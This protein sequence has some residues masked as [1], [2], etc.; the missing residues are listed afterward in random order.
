MNDQ[1]VLQDFRETKALLD[2]HFLLRSGLHSERYFQCALV[3]QYPRRAAKLCSELA[4]KAAGIGAQTVISPALGGLFVGQGVGHALDL[5]HIFLEKD[6]VG[7]LVL[8]RGFTIT[9]GE[10]FLVAED[11]VTKGGRV[12][13][14]I[15]VVRKMGGV[16]VGACV[17]VDRSDGTTNFDVP[18]WSLLKMQFPT[19]APADCP[20]CRDKIPVEKPGSK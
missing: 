9:P 7:G 19:F 4:K 8:R 14:T 15:D 3:L 6:D 5:R 11:V 20:Q 1:D 16:V 12:Q 10:K 18:W 17:L 2:G 13:Q